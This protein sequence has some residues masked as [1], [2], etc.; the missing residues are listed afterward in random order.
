M[1]KINISFCLDVKKMCSVSYDF[2][3]F[4]CAHGPVTSTLEPRIA[5]T[6]HVLV[7]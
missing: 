6:Y 3:C 1:I 4:L 5:A 7:R 2:V